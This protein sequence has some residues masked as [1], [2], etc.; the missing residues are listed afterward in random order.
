[1]RLAARLDRLRKA[2]P[3]PRCSVCD[4]RPRLMLLHVFEGE[5]GASTPAGQVSQP[6]PC[7]ACGNVPPMRVL[8]IIH[9]QAAEN[10][11]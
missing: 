11:S 3:E 1:M 2:A 5:P 7:P 9:E 10:A 8:R 6:E 4:S